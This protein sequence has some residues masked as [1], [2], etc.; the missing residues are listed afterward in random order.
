MVN[1]RQ[2]RVAG[3]QLAAVGQC[4]AEPL[5]L[6]RERWALVRALEPV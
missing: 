2:R 4:E 6:E 3:T 5:E 1:R